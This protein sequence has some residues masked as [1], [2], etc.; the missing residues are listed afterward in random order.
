M[1]AVL[2]T[3]LSPA[4]TGADSPRS[5]VHVLVAAGVTRAALLQAL[6]LIVPAA[7]LG[8]LVHEL[9]AGWRGD[10][11]GAGP[12]CFRS[13]RMSIGLGKRSSGLR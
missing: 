5:V 2:V 4:I 8:D 1:P 7:G 11:G 12:R 13:L 6:G 3:L 9:L 10:A